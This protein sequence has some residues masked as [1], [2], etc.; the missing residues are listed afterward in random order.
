M[1]LAAA[2]PPNPA[3]H[4]EA[5]HLFEQAQDYASA[6]TQ[7]QEVLHRDPGNSSALAGAGEAAYRSGNYD[8]AHRYLELALKANSEDTNARQ[9]LATTDLVLRSNPFR[10]H[11]SDVERNRR[12]TTAF[13]QAEKRLTECAQQT[14]VDL[15]VSGTSSEPFSETPGATAPASPLHD[16][17][18]RWLAAK[19]NL[20]LLRSPAETD[21]PDEIMDVV[22]QIEQQTAAACGPPQGLDLALLLT[23]RERE[24]EV[25]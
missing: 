22:F 20:A 9:L 7:Y 14:H 12:I 4:L 15:N 6:L 17:Q 3:A 13:N 5:A 18:S 11:I 25:R 8:A 1:A 24:A 23:S 19:P 21:L 10:S 16:L 2:L